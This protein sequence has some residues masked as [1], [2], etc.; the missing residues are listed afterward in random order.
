VLSSS[1][2]PLWCLAATQ[3]AVGAVFRHLHTDKV[4]TMG[5]S[6]PE[7]WLVAATIAHYDLDN[8][9]LTVGT[10]PNCIYAHHPYDDD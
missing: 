1:L 8:I 3:P 2:I 10:S 6:T 7:S 9:R 4:L 5:V